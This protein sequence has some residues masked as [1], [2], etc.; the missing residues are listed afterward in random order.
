VQRI[1]GSHSGIMGLP[2]YETATALAGIGF[3]VL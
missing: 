3:P 2:L 1:E